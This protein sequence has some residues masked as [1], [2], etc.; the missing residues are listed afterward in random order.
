MTAP[1]RSAGEVGGERGE[2]F[3]SPS[4]AVLSRDQKELAKRKWKRDVLNS[5]KAVLGC[6]D[7][8]THEGRMDFDHRDKTTKLFKINCNLDKSWTAIWSEVVK[9]DVRCASC[10]AK[11]H[12]RDE[13]G[14]RAPRRGVA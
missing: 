2:V 4:H 12:H 11:R 7:C 6:V 14:L 3:V 9:C 5:Y 1:L 10:H 8:G 13:P